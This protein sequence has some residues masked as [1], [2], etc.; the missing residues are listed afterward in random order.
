[1][2]QVVQTGQGYTRILNT[3]REGHCDGSPGD[4]ER[5]L[6]GW[7]WIYTDQIE[8]LG[9]KRKGRKQGRK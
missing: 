5:L 1:M 2:S 8:H 7:S 4:S 3:L 9:K 6:A